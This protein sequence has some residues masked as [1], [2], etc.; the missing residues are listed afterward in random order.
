VEGRGWGYWRDD[1]NGNITWVTVDTDRPPPKKEQP[2]NDG[3]EDVSLQTGNVIVW[4][5]TLNGGNGGWRDTG[6]KPVKD[7]GHRDGDQRINERTGNVDEWDSTLNGGAGGWK[8]TGAK[9]YE[10]PKE[11]VPREFPDGSMRQWDPTAKEWVIIADAPPKDT[12]AMDIARMQIEANAANAAAQRAFDAQENAAQRAFQA[13]Q[14]RL[15]RRQAIDIE[16]ARGKREYERI[17]LD[18]AK[19]FSEAVNSVDP[20]ALPAFL[21]AGGGALGGGSLANAESTGANAITE[22]ALLP[23]AKMLGIARSSYTPLGYSDGGEDGGG[24]GLVDS[25]LGVGFGGL[26]G[27]SSGLGLRDV[28]PRATGG[29]YAEDPGDEFYV[30]QPYGGGFMRPKAVPRMAQGGMTTAPQMIVGDAPTQNP[31]GGP[32]N[33]EV[34]MNPTGAPLTVKPLGQMKGGLGKGFFSLVPRFAFGTDFDWSGFGDTSQPTTKPVDASAWEAAGRGIWD[35]LGGFG[36]KPKTAPADPNAGQI[37]DADGNPII[38]AEDRANMEKVR[39]LRQKV[40]LPLDKN[41]GFQLDW[42][43][44]LP[45]MQRAQLLALQART[46]VSADDWAAEFERN[47]LGGVERTGLGVR[48]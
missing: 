40:K 35:L 24:N 5:S 18:A 44:Q 14:N 13:E 42:W 36:G 15:D 8:D 48:Y 25:G 19:A 27:L 11:P 6:K 43:N 23:A 31:F 41:Y 30:S 39:A 47:R 45:T 3:D 26:G 2:H 22:N 16:N 37:L 20:T 34:I 9:P 1:G 33:P 38:T 7:S 12:T 4:D 29:L 28:A 32:A 46:G 21:A 10:E 17:K